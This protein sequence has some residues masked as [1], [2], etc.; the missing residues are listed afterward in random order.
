MVVLVMCHLVPSCFSQHRGHSRL[1]SHT[2]LPQF[3]ETVTGWLN[4]TVTEDLLVYGAL[5]TVV[6]LPRAISDPIDAH[7]V[8]R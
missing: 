1:T 4:P 2:H 8:K 3:G 5:Q 6:S 7:Y